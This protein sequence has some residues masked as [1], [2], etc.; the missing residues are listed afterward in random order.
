MDYLFTNTPLESL[1]TECLIIAIYEDKQLSSAANQLDKLTN[2][3]ITSVV[4]R[5]DIK[6]KVEDTLLINY[7]PQSLQ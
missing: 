1:A 4:G 5:G 3:L 2:G 6:G 7:L